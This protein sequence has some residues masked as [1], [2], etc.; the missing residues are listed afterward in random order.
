MEIVTKLITVIGSIIT[1]IGLV[2]VLMGLFTWYK[3]F[4]NENV[5]KVDQGINSMILGGVVGTI[6]ASVTV[7]INAALGNISF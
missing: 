4:K 3:G 6:A 2:N 1:A 5:E 7:A